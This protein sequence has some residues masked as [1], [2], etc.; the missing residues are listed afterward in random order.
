MTE[1]RTGAH[2]VRLL[3]PPGGP[4]EIDV[5]FSTFS[6]RIDCQL[7]DKR[8]A[9]WAALP[10]IAREIITAVWRAPRRIQHTRAWLICSR[11]VPADVCRHPVA[12]ADG[13][14]SRI[15]HPGRRHA[16][17]RSTCHDVEQPTVA[18]R[19][20]HSR[21]IWPVHDSKTTRPS[22]SGST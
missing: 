11:N 17:P 9:F 10:E 20:C 13:A 5:G 1:A 19:T 4:W 15:I 7:F 8:G 2:R 18:Q 12:P 3:L 22:T 16:H 14:S 6:P 21:R